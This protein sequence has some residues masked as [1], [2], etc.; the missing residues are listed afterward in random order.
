MNM[1]YRKILLIVSAL[2]ILL[3]LA[4]TI[5][6]MLDI[7]LLKSVIPGYSS[8]KFNTAICL[9]IS[10]FIFYTLVEKINQ[11][12]VVLL[13]SILILI[14]IA[15][16]SQDV[17]HYQLGLDQLFFTDKEEPRPGRMASTTALSFVLLG[18]SFLFIS[19]KA[20]KTVGQF[21][22]HL[23]SLISFIAIVGYLFDVPVFYK[24]SL[25]SSMAVH[26][27]IAIFVLSIG[28]SLLNPTLGLTSIF[29][30][31]TTGSKMAQRL[32]PK[33]VIA[34]LGLG[35]LRIEAH[36]FNLLDVE[37]GIALFATSFVVVG[38]FLVWQTAI[39]LD[40]TDIKR[41]D[42][43]NEI[44]KLNENLK[45]LVALRNQELKAIFDSAQVSIIGTDL[46]GVITHFNKGAEDLL[47]YS[48]EDIVGKKTP[49]IIHI[50]GELVQRGNELTKQFGREIKGFDVFVELAKQG[51]YESREWTYRRK[52]GTSFP[53]Q[54]VVTAIHDRNEN[55]SGFLG[56]ATDISEQKAQQAIIE[57]QKKELQALNATKDK[58]FSI[59]AHDLKTPLNSLTAFST[60][61]IDHYDSLS[62]EEILA[63]SKQLKSSV[64]NTIKMADNLITWAM[65]QMNDLDYS[66]ELIQ[67]KE[68]VANILEIYKDVAN[69]KGINV[70]CSIGDSLT[71]FGDKNQIE[72]IIR[73]LVNNAVKFTD[74][75]GFVSLEAKS[76]PD[77][78]VE[79]SVSDSGVGISD[80]MKA[81]L[82]S[83]EK[84]QSKN[85]TAGEKGTGLGLMLS[86]EF[87][88]LNGGQID[89][90]SSLDKGTTFHIRFKSSNN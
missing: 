67:V 38:L 56:I 44:I 42:A 51:K 9:I 68:I 66:P 13:S 47:G 84:K 27:A 89:V 90:E 16:F 74:K 76:L 37:F 58:F 43:E 21:T 64:D 62:K 30:G 75:G 23:I 39:S 82:F 71:I 7:T 5:G 3:G 81:K 11:N 45:E 40:K 32:F 78:V 18:L 10:G 41:I 55:I 48:K 61:L 12:I 59:V 35:F 60:L 20:T 86:Y 73:N 25:L 85:G 46:S 8:M 28:V 87:A 26:T 69:N 49:A 52:D 88:K 22:L 24:L 53:V 31:K 54:L 57:I 70:S 1:G 50:E 65:I 33:M 80:E 6:W 17:F 19:A 15:S 63:M 77:G 4:V 2:T 83:I 72:F 36:R 34:I 79:I 14:S 29:A